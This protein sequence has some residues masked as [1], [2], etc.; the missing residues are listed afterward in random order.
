[1]DDIEELCERII[2]ID[3]GVIAYEGSLDNF[4]K[5]YS[6]WKRIQ[7]YFK[8][9]KGKRK[10]NGIKRKY[11]IKEISKNNIEIKVPIKESLGGVLSKLVN[12]LEVIDLSITEPKLENIVA[13]LYQKNKKN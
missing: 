3:K 10:F 1:M 2:L 4:K 9:I 13:N 11:E 5:T 8:E 6:N 7:V 12:S